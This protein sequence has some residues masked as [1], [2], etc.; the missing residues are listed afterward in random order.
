[1]GICTEVNFIRNGKKIH[2]YSW[3][4]ESNT[5]ELYTNE[6]YAC[7]ISYYDTLTNVFILFFAGEFFIHEITVKYIDFHQRAQS[8]W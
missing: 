5:L 3:E 7:V 6:Y 1:M 2:T 8:V 4:L